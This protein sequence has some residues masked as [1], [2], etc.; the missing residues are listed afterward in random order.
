MPSSDMTACFHGGTV[1][2]GAYAHACIFSHWLGVTGPRE[3]G[4][5]IRGAM[6]RRNLLLLLSHSH[7][8]TTASF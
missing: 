1:L 5:T 2:A 6:D 8:G 4:D 7:S 3:E